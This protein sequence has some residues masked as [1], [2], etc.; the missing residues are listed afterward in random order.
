M[1]CNQCGNQA[2]EEQNYC[3]QCGGYL[4]TGNLPM[5]G[6]EVNFNYCRKC[7][8]ELNGR[9]CTNCGEVSV[10][11]IVK[12]K[13]SVFSREQFKPNTS[14]HT[15]SKKE[16]NNSPINLKALSIEKLSKENILPW[17]KQGIIFSVILTIIGVVL[18]FLGG[19]LLQENVL[20]EGF[21]YMG[22]LERNMLDTLINGASSIFAFIYGAKRIWSIKLGSDIYA[23]I[24]LTLPF[25]GLLLT[26]AI[27]WLSEKIRFS[28]SNQ[29]L[30]LLGAAILSLIGGVFT[31]IGGLL[32]TKRMEFSNSDIL[33]WDYW[34][35][36]SEFNFIKVTSSIHI[37]DTFIVGALVIF[38]VLL[39]VIHQREQRSLLVEL[40]QKII[41]TVVGF[42]ALMAFS[43]MVKFL[44]ER[45]DVIIE[46]VE[47][48]I[49]SG[50]GLLIKLIICFIY[51]TGLIL[52]M[53]ATGHFN[54]MEMMI[55]S[56]SVLKLK[57]DLMNISY[58]YYGVEDKISNVM[59]WFFLVAVILMII[60]VAGVAYRYWKERN[61]SL[62]SAAK[63]AG[64]I[65][66]IIGGVLSIVTKMASFGLALQLKVSD[67]YYRDL[68]GIDK[69]KYKLSMHSGSSNMILTWILI[70]VITFILFMLMYWLYSQNLGAL[71]S[72]MSH[73]HFKSIWCAIAIFCIILMVR[74]DIYDINDSTT[75]YFEESIDRFKDAL[76][77]I[78]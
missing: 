74:F 27:I 60:M 70:G 75:S 3:A 6:N 40:T 7:G 62:A 18:S 55:N 54:W 43:M 61:I 78:G 58:K 72:I 39:F 34:S 65:S 2:G 63:E 49:S 50:W 69:S 25:W 16:I 24:A 66:T 11:T 57:I 14:N 26:V 31:V 32:F 5:Q 77:D 17:I 38:L 47:D 30:S 12:V 4:K 19:M 44:F 9:Y 8:Y 53:L 15:K 33:R 23:Q 64:L 41:L 68:I 51:L 29:K 67:S 22:T 1:F 46:P 52:T 13:S 59:R 71:H 42:S 28:I 35:E 37:I 76:D 56:D 45:W 21:Q 36:Y 48:G 10:E 20:D 73:I